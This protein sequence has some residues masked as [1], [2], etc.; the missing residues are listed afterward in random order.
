MAPT[1]G[2]KVN[3]I[4]YSGYVGQGKK[5]E[6]LEQ[7]LATKLENE[8]IVTVNSGTSALFL[9][10]QLLVRFRGCEDSEVLVCP[11]TC[12]AT[13]SAILSNGL[14]PKWVDIDNSNYMMDL[15]DLKSK[16]SPNT[17][18]I[19]LVHW[20]G[21][22]INYE[23]LNEILDECDDMWG[24]RPYVVEDC[25]HALG[26]E[27]RDSPLSSRNWS[28]VNDNIR[29]YSLQAIKSVNSIDGGFITFPRH[30]EDL[31]KKAMLMRWYG[32]DRNATNAS[33]S[34]IDSSILDWGYKLHMN[35]VNATIALENLKHL[36]EIIEKQRANTQYYRYN[37]KD[38]YTA[39]ITLGE[40]LCKSSCWLFTIEV[41]DRPKFIQ[42]MKDKGIMVSQ[43]HTRNDRQPCVSEYKCFLPML[44]LYQ[45]DYCCIP[46]GW[47]IT[48]EER[49]YITKCVNEY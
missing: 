38:D 48:K 24:F 21:Y 41:P 8:H 36:D 12:F 30:D 3:D 13:T 19:M 22:T 6:E 27:W 34:R 44:D 11:L 33:D 49:E 37:I 4:L 9:A 35:D 5:V 39:H 42:Y 2:E 14:K 18:I 20:G 46:V 10:L 40:H 1:V 31:Y 25:A 15:D 28:D 17:K 45:S 29:C 32:I 43:V 26:T 23:K 16:L 7:Y 47:W